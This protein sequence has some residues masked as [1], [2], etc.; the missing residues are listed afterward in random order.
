MSGGATRE[1]VVISGIVENRPHLDK[2]LPISFDKEGGGFDSIFLFE[3]EEISM[4]AHFFA[5]LGS[6]STLVEIAERVALLEFGK[7]LGRE[8]S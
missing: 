1:A 4:P 6:G 7:F 8:D 3:T 5:E 2:G